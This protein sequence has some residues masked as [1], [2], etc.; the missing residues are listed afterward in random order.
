MYGLFIL[1]SSSNCQ[2]LIRVLLKPAPRPDRSRLEDF[3]FYFVNS[4]R[5]PNI[6]PR[7]TVLVPFFLSAEY[8]YNDKLFFV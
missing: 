1:N 7:G 3:L 6:A 2:I 4:Y 8:A 5:Q